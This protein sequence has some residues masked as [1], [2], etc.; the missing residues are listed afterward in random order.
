MSCDGRGA[1]QVGEG[2]MPW[3]TE[4]LM[5]DV[6]GDCGERM[7]LGG[8]GYGVE[9]VSRVVTS[10]DHLARPSILDRTTKVIKFD[11]NGVFTSMLLNKD[12]IFD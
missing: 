5:P 10:E 4:P 2:V 12:N 9:L 7:V 8:L 1:K 6:R 11:V 3:M